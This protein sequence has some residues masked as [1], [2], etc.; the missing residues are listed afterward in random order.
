VLV[1]AAAL[2]CGLASSARAQEAGEPATPGLV[3]EQP[4]EGRFVKTDRGY[5]VP[6]EMTIPGT[7]VTFEMVPISGGTFTMGSPETEE[8]RQEDEG[9]QVQVEVAP[10]WMG[11]YEITWEEY[12]QY[13]RM[14]D[15]FKDLATLR[16]TLVKVDEETTQ[17]LQQRTAL[18]EAL[19]KY[20][21]LQQRLETGRSVVD[22]I[23]APTKLYE[24]SFTFEFG[25]EPRQPAVTMTQYAAKQYTKWLSRLTGQFHRLPGEAEWE[26]ACRAGTTTAYSFGD[27]PAELGEYAWFFEN[28]DFKT[29][30][31]GKKKPNPWGL[32][33]MHGNVAEWVLD[34]YKPQTYERYGGGPVSAEEAIVWPTVEFPRVVRGGHWDSDPEGCRSAARMASHDVDWKSLDPNLPL[35]PWWFTSDPA[36]GVGFRIVRPLDAPPESEHGKYWEADVD[37]IRSAVAD[38]LREGRGAQESID[39][40]LPEVIEQLRA[41]KETV[42]GSN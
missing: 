33:D 17:R 41:V 42:N 11:K 32:Y 14:Y 10:F 39:P 8:G 5:M 27:D 38:R 19:D 30:E 20:N 21:A 29:S 12:K 24:P 6:Y 37:A 26:Y 22:A 28:F 13:M 35:S 2:G 31:V 18:T 15:V 25:E 16:S 4:A 3:A 40:L 34:E 36:R 9:P 7:D 1:A 23:T